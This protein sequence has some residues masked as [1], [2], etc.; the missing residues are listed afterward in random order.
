MRYMLGFAFLLGNL[1][2]YFLAKD[3]RFKRMIIFSLI[4]GFMYIYLEIMLF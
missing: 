3:T 1:A 4:M 2:I